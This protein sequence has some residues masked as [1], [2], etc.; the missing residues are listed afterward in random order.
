MP[1][2]RLHVEGRPVPMPNGWNR[3]YQHCSN[4]K[5]FYAHYYKN[6]KSLCGIKEPCGNDF[7]DI[8]IDDFPRHKV[9]PVC[10]AIKNGGV[11]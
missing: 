8:D 11:I 6:S 7:V 1:K 10:L 9:C 5:D 2:Q 3:K 4:D